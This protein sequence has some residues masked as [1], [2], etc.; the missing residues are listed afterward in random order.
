MLLLLLLLLLV[1]LTLLKAQMRFNA[2]MVAKPLFKPNRLEHYAQRINGRARHSHQ[3]RE[4][5]LCL[6]QVSCIIFF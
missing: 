1:I 6:R 5:L 4:G 3:K 2:A